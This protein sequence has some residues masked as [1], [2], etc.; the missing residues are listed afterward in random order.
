MEDKKGFVEDLGY[1]LNK[2][3][4]GIESMEYFKPGEEYNEEVVITYRGGYQQTVNVTMDSIATI[5]R[6][7]A[8]NI[9]L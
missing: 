5:L 8:R 1:L 4:R 9:E 7:I 6:D 2:H 3:Y